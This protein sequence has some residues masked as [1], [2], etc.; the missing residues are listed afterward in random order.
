M[1]DLLIQEGEFYYDKELYDSEEIISSFLKKM[2]NYPEEH[3]DE[4][5]SR[6]TSYKFSR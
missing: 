5:R 3:Y 4:K 1:K 6:K 2:N